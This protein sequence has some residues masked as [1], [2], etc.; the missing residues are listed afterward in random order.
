MSKNVKRVI[1]VFIV[2][3]LLLS[4]SMLVASYGFKPMVSLDYGYYKF[5]KNY[6]ITSSGGEPIQ[7]SNDMGYEQVIRFSRYE[8]PILTR[9]RYTFA[10]WYKDIGYTVAWINGQDTVTRDIT[11]YAKW[12]KST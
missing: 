3:C 4:M 9:D 5:D 11:L 12:V 8:P 1:V 7:Q 6:F 10:G 2:V